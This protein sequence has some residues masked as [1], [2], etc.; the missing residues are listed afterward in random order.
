M[1][2]NQTSMT[3]NQRLRRLTTSMTWTMATGSITLNQPSMAL[4]MLSL[5]M[6]ASHIVPM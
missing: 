6:E 4:N 1:T 2:L 3:S 5:V